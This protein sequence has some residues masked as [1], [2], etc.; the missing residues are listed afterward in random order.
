MQDYTVFAKNG[1]KNICSVMDLHPGTSM[2]SVMALLMSC[3][4]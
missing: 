1:V 4:V 2:L 3:S